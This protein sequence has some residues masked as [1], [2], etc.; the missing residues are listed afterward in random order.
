M[1]VFQ[2]AFDA[3]QNPILKD[4]DVIELMANGT[5][6]LQY[7]QMLNGFVNR[8]VDFSP[9]DKV[10]TVPAEMI[11]IW[12]DQALKEAE[13]LPKRIKRWEEMLELLK[14]IERGTT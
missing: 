3:D 4:Y 8:F 13:L 5:L 12:L 6:K 14:T 7:T 2:M 11:Q 10:H 1:K 9:P